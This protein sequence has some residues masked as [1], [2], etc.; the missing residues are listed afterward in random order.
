MSG[1]PRFIELKLASGMTT[2]HRLHDLAD[3]LNL[4][5]SAELPASLSEQLHPYVRAKFDEL[6]HAAQTPDPYG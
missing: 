3:I 2:P 6:W 1:L 4:I 5:R